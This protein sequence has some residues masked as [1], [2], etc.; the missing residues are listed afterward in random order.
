MAAKIVEIADAVV[1]HLASQDFLGG[2]IVDRGFEPPATLGQVQ[3]GRVTV[4]P[5]TRLMSMADRAGRY[6]Y[7]YGV[8]IALHKSLTGP[9]Q[10]GA[11]DLLLE[12]VEQTADA[13]KAQNFAGCNVVA[14][15]QE[16]L[17]SLVM[18]SGAATFQSVMR[19]MLKDLR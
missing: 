12:V 8:D 11:I 6:S 14:I 2:W 17:Q 5:V 4:A 1:V 19:L 9:T 18:I 13:L 15:D 10:P 16:E 7:D 3:A